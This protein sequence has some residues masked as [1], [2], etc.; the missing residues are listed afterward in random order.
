MFESIYKKRKNPL[1]NLAGWGLLGLIC[2]IFMFVG[3]SPNVNFMG[4]SAAVA[5]VNG[6]A[7][8]YSD[9][10][11]YFER[12]E[13]SR[14]NTKLSSAERQQL[15]KEVVN[16]LVNRAL[17][18]QSARKQ[19]IVIGAEEIRDFLRQIPQFQENGQFSVLK[20]K[21]L[22]RA[23]GMSEARF[24]E[25][26]VE[27][28]LVQKMNGYYQKITE[29]DKMI[30]DHEDDVSKI[31]MDVDFIRKAKS[32]LVSDN[33]L[34]PQEVEAFAKNKA[35]QISKY[36]K[37]HSK[38]FTTEET[39]TA[40]H[41]L[42]KITPQFDED[43]ALAKI[44]EIQ[45]QLKPDNFSELAKKF[46]EDPGSKDRGG[47]LGSFT[48]ERMVPEFSAQAFSVPV[49][50][51]SPPFK[52]NFGYH[53][54]KVNART[55]KKTQDFEQVKMDIAKKLLK[56]EKVESAVKDIKQALATPETAQALIA[57]KGWTWD[58]TGPFGLGDI[59]IP[60]IGDNTA[61][62]N[63]AM[64]LD[65]K[66]PIYKDVLEKD[67]VYYIVKLKSLEKS[68]SPG[69]E[70][71]MDMFKQIFA[72]QKSYETFQSWM[73]HLRKNASIQINTKILSQN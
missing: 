29:D 40:Q 2:I 45:A 1:F 18:L 49:G 33:E 46:S 61:V 55:E 65:S 71:N 44:K 25:K 35:D 12:V 14:G 11:R 39:A 37:D 17:I 54:L 10:N 8:S 42:I 51:V 56:E 41:I 32:E 57:K 58:S 24:E 48:R 13:E 7:I 21:E 73:D 23:Q 19:G 16:S 5:N 66:N 50:Q 4:S 31:K 63:A 62:L 36:Y 59:M 20:Y 47:D 27:D 64:T 60:K 26:I 3:Y 69:K 72:R 28:L 30:Q 6:E 9:F 52:T 15:Q 68:T 38:E 67:G 34:S 70:P 22:V 43:K 53:I